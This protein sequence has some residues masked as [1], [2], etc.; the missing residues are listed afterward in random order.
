M[1]PASLWLWCSSWREEAWKVWKP[2]WHPQK[3]KK[4]HFNE[5]KNRLR[6]YQAVGFSLQ[7]KFH[8]LES[9]S[10]IL[11]FNVPDFCNMNICK[12][13]SFCGLWCPAHENW[14]ATKHDSR[15]YTFD[16]VLHGRKRGLCHSVLNDHPTSSRLGCHLPQSSAS[17]YGPQIGAGKGHVFHATSY[18]PWVIMQ[19][20]GDD[21]ISLGTTVISLKDP[22]TGARVKTPVRFKGTNGL[23]SFDLDAFLA[24]AQRSRKW[25]CPHSMRHS[26]V[27]D[28]QIDGFI[29]A[30]LK[31]LEVK[32][33]CG[34]KRSK[35]PRYK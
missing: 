19:V 3:P 17:L 31:A 28:L 25:Q 15:S 4:K 20:G 24:M 12:I 9:L 5:S 23:A 21:D 7:N 1:I 18:W 33:Y 27:Q 29:A 30:I 34:F 22:L 35:G 8:C 11:S 6:Q 26:R 14:F 13:L 2:W 32:F 10:P 16:I